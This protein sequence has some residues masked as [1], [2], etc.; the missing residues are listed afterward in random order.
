M[1]KKFIMIAKMHKQKQ[2]PGSVLKKETLLQVFSCEFCEI[3]KSTF[4]YRAPPESASA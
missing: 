2:S 4:F 1:F 3:L